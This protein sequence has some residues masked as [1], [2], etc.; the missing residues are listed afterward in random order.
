MEKMRQGAR[1]P[2]FLLGLVAIVKADEI[3]KLNYG[4]L[5]SRERKQPPI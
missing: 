5:A 1:E 3:Q 4:S 2:F